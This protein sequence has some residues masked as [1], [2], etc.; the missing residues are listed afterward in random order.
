M[1][2]EDPFLTGEYVMHYSRGMQ[3]GNDPK[4]IKVVSTAKHYADYDLE[5]NWGTDR[6]SFNA[7]VNDQDQV[8][9]YWPAWRA[10]VEGAHIHSIMCSYNAVNDVPSCGNN[11]FM[12]VVARGQWGFDGYIV[13]D[14]GA[15][16]DGAFTRYIKEHY[17]GSSDYQVQV[18]ITGGCDLNC[19]SYYVTHIEHSV[20]AGVLKESDVDNAFVRVW[21]HAIR[22]GLLDKVSLHSVDKF[23]K[24]SIQVCLLSNFGT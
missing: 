1:P 3:E 5:G 8:E 24:V 14:C 15:I 19:G 20:G 7:I 22:L 18:A 17:N 16:A 12:N 21:S 9:Y 6:G 23:V 13:S 11:L 10:A 2:G 4:Y